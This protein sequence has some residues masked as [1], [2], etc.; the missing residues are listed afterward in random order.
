MIMPGTH[1]VRPIGDID[2]A[3]AGALVSSWFDLVDR[4]TPTTFVVDLSEV[5]FLDSSG[6]SAFLHLR[7]RVD[8]YGGQVQLRSASWKLRRVLSIAALDRTFPD[9]HLS[10]DS[11]AQAETDIGRPEP[12]RDGVP[13]WPR[14]LPP[15]NIA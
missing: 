5:T 2:V 1:T 13:P 9:A 3:T 14:I 6:L 4:E 15:D 12:D 11:R 10:V 8:S 7:R